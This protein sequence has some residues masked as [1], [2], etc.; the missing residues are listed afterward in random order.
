[1]KHELTFWV[2]GGDM[3]QVHLAQLLAQDGH[4][5]HTY[6]LD[7]GGHAAPDAQ[8]HS[9]CD[10]ISRADCVILPL[11][12]C[13]VPGTLSTPL[14]EQEH[15]LSPVLDLLSPAQTVC[16]GRF[17]SDALNMLA[18]RGL[19]AHDYFER[20]ELTIA[21][22][23][24]TAE[25]AIQLA[26]E[27]LPITIHNARVLVIGYG[28]VGKLTAQRFAALGAKV[29]VAA[30]SYEQLAWAQTLGLG[31]EQIAHLPELLCGYDLVIN[32]V[33]ARV[34]DRNCLAAVRNDALIIDLA[35]KPGGVDM[36]AAAQL[37]RRVIWAL[38]LPG[39]VAPVTAGACIRDTVYN[40]LHQTGN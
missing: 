7:Q 38:S 20:E 26:M 40:I 3:R 32:T 29:S 13:S 5:V 23:V 24:P 33:P 14:S 36:D 39:K 28:R 16:G 37:G 10:G 34:L 6:A 31:A 2:V 9:T 4:T 30:R 25:G 21:N 35:S 18:E 27:E 17:D 8:H 1:M 19:T 22:A 12:V 11:P 15:A